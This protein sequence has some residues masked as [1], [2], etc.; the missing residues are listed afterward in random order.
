MPGGNEKRE[1]R[2]N[3]FRLRTKR[4][5]Q[6]PQKLQMSVATDNGNSDYAERKPQLEVDLSFGEEIEG[7][8]REDASR[9]S[10]LSRSLE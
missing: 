1:R 5:L 7:E 2:N 8:E 6:K 3:K 4:R 9:G 10:A